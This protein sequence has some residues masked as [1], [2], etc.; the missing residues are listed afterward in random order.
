MTYL[1]YTVH[2]LKMK[3]V[4]EIFHWILYETYA[5]YVGAVNPAWSMRLLSFLYLFLKSI[6]RLYLPNHR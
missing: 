2:I 1:R 5:Q 6:K 3:H 4:M